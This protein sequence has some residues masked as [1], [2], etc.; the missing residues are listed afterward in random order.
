MEACLDYIQIYSKLNH[1]TKRQLPAQYYNT[2]M[3]KFCIIMTK[4]LERKKFGVK[5]KEILFI[6]ADFRIT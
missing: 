1:K 3:S 6:K 5:G 4:Q 2:S